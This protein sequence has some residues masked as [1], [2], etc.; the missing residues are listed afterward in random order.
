MRF[1]VAIV[2]LS[3]GN[4]TPSRQGKVEALNSDNPPFSKHLNPPIKIL[5]TGGGRLSLIA[6]LP[7]L[8]CNLRN[9]W[10]VDSS[11]YTVSASLTRFRRQVPYF[12]KLSANCAVFTG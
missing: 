2:S 6:P 12:V 1:S 5:K 9:L 4:L 8:I 11:H 7:F 10:M 3:P